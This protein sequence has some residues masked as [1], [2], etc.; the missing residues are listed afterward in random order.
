MVGANAASGR[1]LPDPDPRWSDLRKRV[2][3]ALVLLPVALA[4][5]WYGGLPFTL[6]VSG[7]AFGM[8][9]EWVRMGDRNVWAL[10]N[11]VLPLIALIAAVLAGDGF[12]I[13]GLEALA[14]GVIVLLCFGGAM[15][16]RVTLAIGM[17]YVG[18]GAVALAWL[19]ADPI[20]GFANVLFLLLIVWGSD[21][22]AY[23]AGRVFGGP[24]L[25]PAISPGKTWSGAVGGLLA[26]M[27]VAAIAAWRLD[28]DASMAR[29]CIL[30]A[31][32]GVTAQAG[33]LLESAIKRHFG[34]KDSGRLIPGHGGLLD[35]FDAVLLVA[36]VAAIL[37]LCV[38]RGV[39]LWQ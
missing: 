38:G 36:P 25:A 28:P 29:A 30:G 2:A 20:A 21:I 17:P 9:Y 11:I 10:P 13:T 7:A 31:A 15:R 37:A 4:C 8:A 3:S 39:V 22:G 1:V 33:D 6:L 18:L 14:V 19:R 16:G 23:L 32:L 24:K 5:L 27:C 12:E 35:R 26:A 34:V